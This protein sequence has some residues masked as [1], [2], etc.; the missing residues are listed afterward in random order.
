MIYR[1]KSGDTLYK[2][3]QRFGTTV[4]RL[5]ELNDI[6]NPN[7]LEVGQK[8]VVPDGDRVE[9]RPKNFDYEVV[10]GLLFI[11]FTDQAIYQAGETIELTLVKVN[12][13]NSPIE[14]NYSSGQRYDFEAYR[15]G[16]RVWT[17]SQGQVFPQ[18]TRTISLDPEEAVVYNVTWEREDD[19]GQQIQAGR[20]QIR[21]WNV[22]QEV[23]DER[24]S[25]FLEVE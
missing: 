11:L 6:E 19:N 18:V 5:V 8:L 12:I 20:Y 14:L 7:Y 25:V 23:S 22:A 13:G 1:V 4:Q 2:I 9:I 10:N 17:W 3:A 15:D 24:L 21:G 16:Q